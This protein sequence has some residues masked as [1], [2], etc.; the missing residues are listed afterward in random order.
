MDLYLSFS[1]SFKYNN[2]SLITST[3]TIINKTEL[4]NEVKNVVSHL[5]FNENMLFDII[6]H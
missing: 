6:H 1:Q 2:T 4:E 5:N 3:T